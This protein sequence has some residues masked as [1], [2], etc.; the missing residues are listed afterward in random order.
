MIREVEEILD[1]TRAWHE[2]DDEA[3]TTPPGLEP[4]LNMPRASSPV[5]DRPVSLDAVASD[6]GG[7]FPLHAK[8]IRS[9]RCAR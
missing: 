3:L 5:V 9:S 1:E 7:G 2:I 8:G 4:T 6:S